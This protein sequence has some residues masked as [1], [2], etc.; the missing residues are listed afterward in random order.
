MANL[1]TDQ[2]GLAPAEL[3]ALR[4]AYG[5]RELDERTAPENPLD[6]FTD[7][8]DAAR[9]AGTV[10][11]NAMTLATANAGGRPSARMVLLKGA[12]DRGLS[13]FTN[14]EG[15]KG[16]ELASNPHAALV[17][18]WPPTERQVRIEGPV[19]AV[20]PR[21]SDEYWNSRPRGSRLGAWASSQSRPLADRRALDVAAADAASRY[22]GDEIPRPSYWVGFRVVPD[23]W[24]FWQGRAD[25][26]HDRVLYVRTPAGWTRSRL[27]P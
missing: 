13:F 22:P 6:L 15:R 2:T 12:D 21:E 27:A 19:E 4:A 17:F 23:R 10:E 3:A 25:R 8:F 14:A 7:W 1:E 26:L 9:A 11:P 5:T 16:G 20:D 18:W 24:E